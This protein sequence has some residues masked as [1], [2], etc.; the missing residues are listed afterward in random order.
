MSKTVHH[1]D[2][3]K[4]VYFENGK[5]ATFGRP[6]P[7]QTPKVTGTP[8]VFAAGPKIPLPSGVAHGMIFQ[9][10]KKIYVAL[11]YEGKD[12]LGRRVQTSYGQPITLTR[13]L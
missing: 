6:K 13:P 1:R 9:H 7:K 3:S 8:Y 5:K 4:T 11:R 12:A 2:G 10:H